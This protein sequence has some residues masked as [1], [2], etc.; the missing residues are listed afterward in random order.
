MAA[1]TTSFE[2]RIARI[3]ARA[4][5]GQNDGFVA[6]GVAEDGFNRKA[7]K[8][9]R[10]KQKGSRSGYMVSVLGGLLTSFVVVGLGMVVLTSGGGSFEDVA[11]A[12][13][14]GSQ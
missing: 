14:L 6:P 1:S 9:Y 2:Q 3:Q 7:T 12:L 8:A 5:T 4:E 11:S 13:L 10:P